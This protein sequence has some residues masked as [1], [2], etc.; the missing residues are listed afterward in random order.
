MVGE[1][2]ASPEELGSGIS[3]FMFLGFMEQ[4]GIGIPVGGSGALTSALIRCIED[5]GG[6]VLAEVEI[7][8]VLVKGGRVSGVHSVDGRIFE[9]RDAVIGGIHPH[10][11]SYLEDSG[12]APDVFE[13]A[14]RTQTSPC[15]CITIHAALNE[16]LRFKAGDHVDQAAFIE[17]LPVSLMQFRRSFDDVRYGELPRDPTK[18]LVFC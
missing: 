18:S 4:Y 15:S 3:L 2:L 5:H 12:V 7:D 8:K 9:A 17:L 10:L 16:K 11:R 13:R 1:N 14:E 6:E